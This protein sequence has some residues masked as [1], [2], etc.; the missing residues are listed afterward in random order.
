MVK[1]SLAQIVI[2]ISINIK[3]SA[4]VSLNNRKMNLI[5]HLLSSQ[6]MN[7]IPNNIIRIK[8]L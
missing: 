1:N 6:L 3:D 2:N 5:K 4:M 8:L 7:R